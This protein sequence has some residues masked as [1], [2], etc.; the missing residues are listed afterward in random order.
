VTSV[1]IQK[2]ESS[3]NYNDFLVG[4]F[5][6]LERSN[7]KPGQLILRSIIMVIFVLLAAQF[8]ATPVAAVA[9]SFSA[10]TIS[11]SY[12]AFPNVMN[13]TLTSPNAEH[14]GYFGNSVAASGSIVVVG[15][16]G[17]TV[18]GQG[19]AG[20][21]YTFNA[22]TGRLIS[23]LTSPS[24]QSGGEF[25]FSVAVSRNLVVVGAPYEVTS[26]GC[27]PGNL[28]CVFGNAYTFNADTGALISTL[29]SPWDHSGG[30]FYFHGLFGSSVAASGN[31]VVVSAPIDR[32]DGQVYTFNAETG[33]SISTFTNPNP[34]FEAGFG[35]SLAVSDNILVVG[36]PNEPV[37][38]QFGAGLTYTFNMDTGALIT[39]FTG[40]NVNYCGDSYPCGLFGDSVAVSRNIVVV[41]AP[42]E[43]ANEQGEA[44]HA[45]IFRSGISFPWNA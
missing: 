21:A 36:A 15:G 24:A 7:K 11:S 3:F 27:A 26:L 42:Y 43:T 5:S 38:G 35:L 31:I 13:S 33:A 20:Q 39:T 45:Y 8:F 14:D 9:P 18:N 1:D 44:G 19:E 23:T 29:T 32:G 40:P 41:G 12:S 30:G 28:A 17:E 25:G 37:N 10:G 2:L 34:H 22:E 16:P 6:G 4:G